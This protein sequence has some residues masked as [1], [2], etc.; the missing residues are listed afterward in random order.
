MKDQLRDLNQT[1][2]LGRKGVNLQM[3]LPQFFWGGKT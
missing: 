2:P 3:P 1:W